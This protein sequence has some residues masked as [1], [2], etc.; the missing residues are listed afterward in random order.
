MI[1]DEDIHASRTCI[2]YRTKHEHLHRC[3]CIHAYGS[4]EEPPQVHMHHPSPRFS[5]SASAPL[6]LP[7][8]LSPFLPL[9]HTL[10]LSLSLSLTLFPSLA[11]FSLSHSFLSLSLARS[12]STPPAPSLS[13]CMFPIASHLM[14][15]F[16][17]SSYLFEMSTFLHPS[18]LF[19]CLTYT[20]THTR[21]RAHTHTRTHTHM[22]TLTR[23]GTACSPH[24]WL[25]GLFQILRA[26]RGRA[27]TNMPRRHNGPALPWRERQTCMGLLCRKT[28][29]RPTHTHH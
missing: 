11:L 29:C 10:S 23:T 17:H 28:R 4:V 7:P 2:H 16:M 18:F 8:S 1:R 12:L 26:Q 5:F 22:H 6:S 3:K 20:H 19:V 14:S 9:L 15:T 13:R 27:R 21:A 25:V 24:S